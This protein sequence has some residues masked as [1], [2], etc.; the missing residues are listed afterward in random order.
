MNQKP[1]S[2]NIDRFWHFSHW[3]VLLQSALCECG[4]TSYY[5]SHCCIEMTPQI[6]TVYW[7]L[8][9]STTSYTFSLSRRHCYPHFTGVRAEVWEA[10]VTHTTC[11]LQSILPVSRCWDLSPV[12][13]KKRIVRIGLFSPNKIRSKAERRLHK[14]FLSIRR[15]LGGRWLGAFVI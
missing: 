14:Y 12:H 3:N 9:M 6:S 10:Y 11:G 7:A 15:I 2:N 5:L 4:V 13:S 1:A 8:S